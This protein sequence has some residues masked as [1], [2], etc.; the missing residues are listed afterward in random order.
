MN[1][2][3]SIKNFTRGGQTFLHNFRMVNQIINRVA[4][5]CFVFFIIISLLVAYI[6]TTE[7]QRY[8]I[9]QLSIAQVMILFNNSAK[10]IFVNP[11]GSTVKIL[12]NQILHATFIHQA[13][14]DVSI[15][16]APFAS[17]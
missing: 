8:L 15:I 4:I 16:A 13:I 2:G 10:Q 6:L 14:R 7:Y 1:S 11:D 5:F 17:V 12:S 9:E 3:S